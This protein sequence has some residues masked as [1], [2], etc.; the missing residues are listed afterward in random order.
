[1]RKIQKS[2]A[3]VRYHTDRDGVT[4]AVYEGRV[5]GTAL[6]DLRGAV[7]RQA[8]DT[9]AYVVRMDSARLLMGVDPFIPPAGMDL[10]TLPGG[11]VICRL[12][13]LEVMRAYARYMS[14]HGVIRT[15][16][17][18]SEIQEA[19]HFAARHAFFSRRR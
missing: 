10:S 4:L 15:V 14:E 7:A 19:L 5:D 9:T 13:Q 12:D 6:V 1:M 3:N 11:A 16:F 8:A 2:Q 17:L 18:D